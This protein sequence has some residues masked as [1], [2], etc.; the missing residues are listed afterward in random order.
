MMVVLFYILY[1]GKPTAAKPSSESSDEDGEQDESYE[2]LEGAY[3]PKDYVSLN[4]SAEVRDL[5]D[6][7]DRFKPQEVELESALKCF[8]P[9]YIPAIGDMDS[10]IKVSIKNSS[11]MNLF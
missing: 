6:Y 7:I 4:V 2:N 3:N 9:E 5:F 8:I 11:L 10:F 1:Q